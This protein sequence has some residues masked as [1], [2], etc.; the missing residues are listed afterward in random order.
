MKLTRCL[1]LV[2][3]ALLAGLAAPGRAGDEQADV[4]ETPLDAPGGLT[5]RVRSEGPPA[6]DVPLQVVCY[7]KYTPAGAGRMS[8]SP[9]ELDRK[10]GGAIASLRGR[11]E[12]AGD[13]R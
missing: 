5:V 3:V 7:F 13:E 10:L 4:R 12:F 9:V 6:A 11:G 2:A 8:G 1:P